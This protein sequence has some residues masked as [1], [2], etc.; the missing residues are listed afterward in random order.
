MKKFFINLIKIFCVLI[1]SAFLLDFIFCVTYKNVKPNKKIQYINTFKNKTV[2]YIFI[3]SSRVENSIIPNIIEKQTNKKC[4]N[5][6]I[7]ALR[8]RDVYTVLKILK[9]NNTKYD[10]V[11]IQVDYHYKYEKSYSKFFNSEL[12]PL[13]G[14]SNSIDFYLKD[15][16]KD[17]FKLKYIPFYKFT[18]AE[19]LIGFRKIFLSALKNKNEFES[20]KGYK[21]I[22]GIGHDKNEIGEEKINENKFIKLINDFAFENKTRVEYFTAPISNYAKPNNFCNQL[23]N[24]IPGLYTFQNEFQNDNLFKDNYHLN[25]EGSVLFTKELIKKLKL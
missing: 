9:E 7:S 12:F 11:F 22:Y 2:N 18:N 20:E 13:I 24:K 17:Y 1:I 10:K 5:F 6:G 14:S 19:Q 16:N 25:H 3:G 4:V 15:I 8:L 21:P 23:K